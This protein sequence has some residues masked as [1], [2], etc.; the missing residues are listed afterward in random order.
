MG[1]DL[2][3]NGLSAKCGSYVRVQKI[4]RLLLEGIKFYI[5][6]EYPNENDAIDYICMLFGD[7]NQIVYENF[8]FEKNQILARINGLDGFLPF[9]HHS[10]N[11]GS[12]SSQEA[13]KFMQ[14]WEITKEY[15]ND[16]LKDFE[17]KFYLEF[18]FLESIQSRE[19]INFF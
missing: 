1:L 6:M 12:L 16:E 8:C 7:K 3:C 4:R 13:K 19:D 18:I 14:T 9:I 10:D 11:S 2:S 17:R 5:E 15:M